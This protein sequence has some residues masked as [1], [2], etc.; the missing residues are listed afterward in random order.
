[1]ELRLQGPSFKH[2]A[3]IHLAP[4]QGKSAAVGFSFHPQPLPLRGQRCGTHHGAPDR[5]GLLWNTLELLGC[6]CWIVGVILGPMEGPE[7]LM[8]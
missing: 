6:G 3:V 7:I 2:A 5:H 4:L 1:M 8:G